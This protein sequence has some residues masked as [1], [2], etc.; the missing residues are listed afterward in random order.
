MDTRKEHQDKAYS[1]F[2]QLRATWDKLFWDAE[3]DFKLHRDMSHSPPSIRQI[4]DGI[5]E[6]GVDYINDHLYE[7][8]LVDEEGELAESKKE[9]VYDRACNALL[10]LARLTAL[11]M[12]QLGNA[13]GKDLHYENLVKCPCQTV[14]DEEL[15]DFLKEASELSASRD[16]EGD[17]WVIKNFDPDKSPELPPHWPWIE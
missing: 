6:E 16:L 5:L 7:E 13:A 11:R 9:E 3:K 12:Y 17:G 2:K 1:E 8:G 4:V 10:S 14:T 15:N